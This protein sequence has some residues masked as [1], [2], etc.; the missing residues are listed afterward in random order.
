MD[1]S[2]TRQDPRYQALLRGHNLRF[3]E[4]VSMG[5]ARIIVCTTPADVHRALQTAVHDGIR[6]TVRS[7][8]HCYENFSANNPG[9]VLLDLSQLN[10]V[11]LDLRTG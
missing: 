5:P 6:P 9:G 8:G 10:T 3:P 2:V 7:G 1:V 11:D 4:N